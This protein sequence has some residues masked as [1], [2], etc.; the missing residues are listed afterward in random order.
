MCSSNVLKEVKAEQTLS[1]SVTEC[2]EDLY[3]KQQQ[4]RIHNAEETETNLIH[5]K[6]CASGLSLTQSSL[7]E[8]ASDA[9]MFTCDTCGTSSSW[10]GNCDVHKS[11]PRRVKSYRCHLCTA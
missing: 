4:C 3:E 7:R 8:L 9:N 5:V 11:S 6:S 10:R 2:S 1:K